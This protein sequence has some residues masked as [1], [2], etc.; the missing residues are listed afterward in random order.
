MHNN[1]C[2]TSKEGQ[3]ESLR[4]GIQHAQEHLADSVLVMLA[5]QSFIT[6]QMLSKMISYMSGEPACRFVDTTS[7]QAIMPP[8]LFSSSIYPELLKLRGDK[9]ARTILKGNFFN[10]ES[11]CDVM[12]KD[13][14][15]MSIQLKITK[16]LKHSNKQNV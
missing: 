2:S 11:F 9:G 3:S 5:D 4:C 6:V 1:Q 12:T 14:H 8:V 7:E 13:W 10:E 16:H 15:S